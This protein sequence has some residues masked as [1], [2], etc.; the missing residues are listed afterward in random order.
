MLNYSKK[1]LYKGNDIM[2]FQ[3]MIDTLA[4]QAWSLPFLLFILGVSVYITIALNF[5]QFRYF[6]SAIRLI[7]RKSDQAKVAG[8]LT[9]LQAFLNTL[10]TNI[11]NGSFAG[12]SVAVSSGGPGAI[13][14][15]LVL[16]TFSMSLRY[17]EVFLGTYYIDKLK[18]NNING[19][20]VAYMSLLPGG[21][22]WSYVFSVLV[23]VVLLII[24]NLAQ[25]HAVASAVHKV[26]GVS[27]YV[28]GLA[29]LLF[30]AYV[31]LGGAERIIKV[32]DLLVPVK[33]GIFLLSAI[34]VLIY[35]YQAV[36][37]AL[38]LMFS[39]ALNPQALLGG[40]FG[41]AL[42]KAMS[43]GFK[44]EVFS[45]EA[46]LGTAAV[47]FGET[48]GQDPVE[49]GVLAM[50]GVFINIHVVC[51]LVALGLIASGVWNNGETSSALVVCAYE[52]VFGR[53][54]GWIILALIIN[55]A[56]SVLV[57]TAYNGRLCWNFLFAGRCGWLYPLI[58]SAI[59]FC[60]TWL[61]VGLVFSLSDL[62]SAVLLLVNLVG[63]LWSIGTIKKA[64]KAYRIK[65]G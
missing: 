44:R 42:Q 10:G 16:A 46:G 41:F 55:F 62:M 40:T 47:A 7:T 28:T 39:S 25:C 60:G 56:V 58:Y 64:L 51:F 2:V 49:N 57:A 43:V 35:H 32:V 27:E 34:V 20:P 18:V 9:P 3:S 45:S 5:V 65:H 13:V 12:M 63:L 15:I 8:E 19:G 33:V 31:F 59:A 36:P 29:V 50:L 23:M 22:V 30:M 37:H 14:W 11:G 54:G 17:A 52:T 1:I 4:Q 38:Y 24:G 53:Y 48:K 6:T 21:K 26:F 61:H